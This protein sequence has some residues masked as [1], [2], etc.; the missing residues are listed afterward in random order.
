MSV[1][2]I[3]VGGGILAFIQFLISR[4]DNRN[5]K[6]KQIL[7]ALNDVQNEIKEIRE[8]LSRRD[9][10]SARVQILR[11]KDE[12][13]NNVTHSQEY[14]EQILDDIETYNK[15][16][17]EYPKFRN[18]RTKAA[19]EYINEEYTRLFKEHKL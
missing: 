1:L 7:A 5:E 18:G 2:S 3:L 12:L 8:E 16:C 19:T 10:V 6:E 4:H 14:F 13:Y 15:Y 9:A 17:N 11:F